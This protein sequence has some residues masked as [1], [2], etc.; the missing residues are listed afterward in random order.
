[1]LRAE[2]D[3]K[4]F[5]QFLEEEICWTFLEQLLQI[6]QYVIPQKSSKVNRKKLLQ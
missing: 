3:E 5:F 4:I 2:T 1:M 6:H